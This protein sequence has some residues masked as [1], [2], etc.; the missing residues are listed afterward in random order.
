MQHSLETVANTAID[1][2]ADSPYT[3]RWDEGG[4]AN[5]PHDATITEGRAHDR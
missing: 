5:G 1:R 4:L 3:P 2:A